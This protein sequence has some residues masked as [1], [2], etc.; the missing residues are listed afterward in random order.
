MTDSTHLRFNMHLG[1]Q[2]PFTTDMLGGECPFCDRESLVDILEERYPLLWLKNKYPVLHDT[3]QTVIIET[4]EC[5]AELSA[6]EKDHLHA[7]FRFGVEKWQELSQ[8]GE[9][10]SV[11]FFKNHGPQSGGSLRHPHM[12]IVGLKE[13]DYQMHVA[14][15]QFEGIAIDRKPGI[16]FNISTHPR[17]G[18]TEFNVLLDDPA[19]LDQLADYVQIATHYVLDRLNR[20]YQSYNLFFYQRSERIVAKIVP[21]FVVSPLFVGFSI[22]QVSSRIEEIAEE[23]R[24]HYLTEDPVAR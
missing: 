13:L 4:D 5:L 24:T 22:P 21:R 1:K 14:D 11:A 8:S 9:F 12:Q 6:Y 7:L 10:R 19:A 3:Y 23:V 20:H 16:T 18:F 15:W 2:K 17:V